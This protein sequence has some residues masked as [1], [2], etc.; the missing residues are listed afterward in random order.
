MI[1]LALVGDVAAR[2]PE[3]R[4]L[5]EHVAPL[6]REA[7]IAFCNHEFPLCDRGEPWPGKAGSVVR[8]EPGAVVALTEAG[9]DVVNLANNHTM[10]YG[11]EGLLQT[12]EVLDAA[13]I[14]HC[15][16]GPNREAAHRPAV[17]ERQSLRV[18]FLG[19]TS[20]YQPGFG[21]TAQRAGVATVR[22]DTAYRQHRRALEEPGAALEVICTPDAADRAAMEE[23]VG[24][25][26]AE[27]DLVV[28]S[29]HWGQ[30]IGAKHLLDYQRE[31][32][33]AAIDA[34]AGL[35]VGHSPHV[36]QAVEVY[37]GGVI[38]Y[39]LAQFGLDFPLAD[40]DTH[41]TAMARCRVVDGRLERVALTP[42]L[43]GEDNRARMADGEEH[44]RIVERLE[45]LSR[46]LGTTFR[47]EGNELVVV[48]T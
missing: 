23:D 29:W 11:P 5:L 18:A 22:V 32:G 44:A 42:A 33:H 13:G 24:R 21:A 10:N 40:V 17:L 25:A 6:F 8:S 2:R 35:I 16:A 3:P 43:I 31:L 27:A 12:I 36:L 20:V 41:D 9:I 14:A 30:S 38:C 1:T 34:G 46:P 26:R 19:Y 7:D 4:A 28:V 15:G 48:P 37:G 45:R 39:S 47:A